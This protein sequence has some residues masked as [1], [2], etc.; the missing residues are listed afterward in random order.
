M[1]ETLAR[2]WAA[3]GRRR[4]VPAAAI[5]HALDFASWRSLVHP[6]GLA[7]DEAVDVMLQTVDS[8]ADR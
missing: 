1:R 8:I 2:G 6:L 7:D 5:G 4:V 3:R